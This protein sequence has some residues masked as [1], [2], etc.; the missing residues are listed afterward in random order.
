MESGGGHCG[1]LSRPWRDA[2]CICLFAQAHTHGFTRFPGMLRGNAL[3]A[4]SSVTSTTS[5]CEAR[6]GEHLRNVPVEHHNTRHRAPVAR[7]DPL[8]AL[9]L[10]HTCTAWNMRETVAVL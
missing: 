1:G 4:C 7:A 8:K 3:N 10:P 6:L 2:V 5:C 9:N